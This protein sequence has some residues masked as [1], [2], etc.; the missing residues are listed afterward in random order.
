MQ[1]DSIITS[2]NEALS[3]S[4]EC[5]PGIAYGLAEPVIRREDG[6]TEES[7]TDVDY[8]AIIDSD[9]E[10]SDVFVDDRY[11]M[12]LYH[13][14]I[15]KT[16]E[17]LANKGF[18]DKMQNICIAD[19]YLVCWGFRSSLIAEDVEQ[20]IISKLPEKIKVV[21]TEFDRK[22]VFTTEFNGINFFLP[23]EIF[24][25][26]LR[27]RVQYE[28]KPPCLEINEIFTCTS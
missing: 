22:R 13:R 20:F 10:C 19:F 18:G 21:T 15:S 25:F 8:P 1:I 4:L 9:G 28:V 17:T 11:K 24:L 27:Y 5:V 6:D 16:Y 2:I 3:E 12:G 23:P 26:S 7:T 14:L